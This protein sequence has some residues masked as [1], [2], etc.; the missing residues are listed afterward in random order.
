MRYDIIRVNA[1]KL[2]DVDFDAIEGMS[3]VD[4]SDGAKAAYDTIAKLA[5][6]DEG[7]FFQ[8]ECQDDRINATMCGYNEPIYDEET[9]EFFISSGGDISQYLEL[10]WN[11]IGGVFCANIDNDMQGTAKINFVKDNIIQSAVIADGANWRVIGFLPKSL[12]DSELTGEWRFN[13]FRI[14]R[15]EDNSMVLMAYSPTFVENFHK[16]I[17]FARLIFA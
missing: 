10:E 14:K 2:Q 8:F 7:I 16:P 9:V 4:N 13:A 1:T 17:S 6:N 5:Y 3:L 11:A 15:R 12:F